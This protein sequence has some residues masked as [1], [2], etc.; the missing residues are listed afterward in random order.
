MTQI[1]PEWP[2]QIPAIAI[3]R[4]SQVAVVV[5]NPNELISLRR[6]TTLECCHL[7]RRKDK[8]IDKVMGDLISNTQ[9]YKMTG[10][11]IVVSCLAKIFKKFALSK[12]LFDRLNKYLFF[13]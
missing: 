4:A 10:N 12:I 13:M 9:L 11:S 3:R 7:M 2:D 6:L 5:K 8:A 1:P